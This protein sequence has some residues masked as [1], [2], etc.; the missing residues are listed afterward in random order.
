MAGTELYKHLVKTKEAIH[1]G[2]R[3]L[4][5]DPPGLEPGLF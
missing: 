1:H 5:V 2:G 3:P 4:S